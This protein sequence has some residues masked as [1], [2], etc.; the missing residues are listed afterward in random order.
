MHR[1]RDA[2]TSNPGNLVAN[3]PCKL[4]TL[5]SC[6]ARQLRSCTTA[7]SGKNLNGV[8]VG[9]TSPAIHHMNASYIRRPIRVEVINNWA[10]LT[11]K[12]RGV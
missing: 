1:C 4:E 3:C 9:V 6:A 11:C 2:P 7:F 5:D 10:M 8:R 12:T